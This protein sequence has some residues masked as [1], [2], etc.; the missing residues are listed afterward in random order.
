MPVVDGG[1]G[2]DGDGGAGGT[3]VY[4][5]GPPAV[6]KLTIATR[7]AARTGAEVFHNHL[8]VNA[9]APVFGFGTPAFTEVLHRVRLDV[10]ATA[11]REG[12]DLV[13]TNSSVWAVPGGRER[14]AAFASRA[15]AAV[16]AHGGRTVFV[17]V[18]APVPTLE[19]R[20][21]DESRRAHGKLVDVGRLRDLLATHDPSPLHPDDLTVDSAELTPDQAADRIAARLAVGTPRP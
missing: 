6:G 10:F 3:L 9:L 17:R 1:G 13:F 18:T 20:V 5:Y 11:A 12:I 21:A 4:L 8:T 19:A 7:L 14:F 2:G 15:G 16:A